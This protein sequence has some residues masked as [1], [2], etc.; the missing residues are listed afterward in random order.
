MN[1][2]KNGVPNRVLL[3]DD[4]REVLLLNGEYLKRKGLEVFLAEN[5]PSAME[6]LKKNTVDCIV[7]DVMMPGTDGFEAFED[8]RRLSQAPILFLTGRTEE[9]DRIRGLTL[10]ADDYI[11]K[12]CSLEELALRIRINIRR[13]ARKPEKESVL[14]FPPLRLELLQHKA[15]HLNEEILLSNREYELL[16]LFARNPGR[17]LSFREIGQQLYNGYIEADRK[18]IMMTASRL[19]KKLEGYVGMEN[20]I[21]TVWGKGYRFRG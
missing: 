14:E 4:D 17:E 13:S 21:E 15:F 5:A 11:I 12:P 7:L 2:E 20:I 18:N 16:A 3:V 10:G 6:Q 19:R 8:I 9:A 1:E